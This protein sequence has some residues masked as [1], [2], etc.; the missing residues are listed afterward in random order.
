MVADHPQIDNAPGLTWRKRAKGWEARWQC[1]TDLSRRGYPLKSA[2]LWS[3]EAPDELDVDLIRNECLRLQN[4]MLIWGRGGIPQVMTFDGTIRGLIDAYQKDKDSPYRKLRYATRVYYET[5]CRR[6]IADW[7][8]YQVNEIKARDLRRWH[9]KFEAEG[10]IP[11]GHACVGMLRTVLTFGSTILEDEKCKLLRVTLHDMRFPMGKARTVTLSAEQ[12]IAIRAEAH[13]RGRH[14]IALAQAFQ[15]ELMLRQK[16]VIGEWIPISEVA[17]SPVIWGNS[18]W[19]RG[20]TW[21]EIDSALV[22]DHITSKRN[23][24]IRV[25]LRPASMIMEELDLAFPGWG[26]DKANL[27]AGG[28]VIV[29]ETTG[30]PWNANEFR[31]HWR[32]CAKAVGIPDDVRNMDS[33]AGAITEATQSGAPLESIKQAATHSDISMTQRYARG[34]EEKTADVLNLRQAFRANKSGTDGA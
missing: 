23:K 34:A 32:I 5:L 14:S 21:S 9:E 3:G 26:G 12:A 17:P 1:R 29:C 13:K 4:D 30:V 11:M 25:P 15:F 31:R 10:H 19:V 22:L 33:R 7:G 6:L 2:R 28:P 24:P 18:K 20:I 27:P 16:D 8:T